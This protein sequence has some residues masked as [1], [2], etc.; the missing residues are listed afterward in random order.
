MQRQ[1]LQK[2]SCRFKLI[3]S[4]LENHELIA[5]RHVSLDW[6]LSTTLRCPSGTRSMYSIFPSSLSLALISFLPRIVMR[7][8]STLTLSSFPSKP[9]TLARTLIRSSDSDMETETGRKS[10]DSARNQSSQS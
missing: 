7:Y 4:F 5:A 10:S 8:G 2:L 6:G 1:V 9:R 3:L